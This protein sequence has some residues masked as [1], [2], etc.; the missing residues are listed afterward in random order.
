MWHGP[1]L[2][3]GLGKTINVSRG[4]FA[5]VSRVERRLLRTVRAPG[6][7]KIK[8]SKAAFACNLEERKLDRSEW[9]FLP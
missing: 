3:Q 7:R 8:N 2:S 1:L 9:N 6:L 5:I 4:L